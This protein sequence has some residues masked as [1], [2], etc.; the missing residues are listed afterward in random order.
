VTT[1]KDRK[2]RG[3]WGQIKSYRKERQNNIKNFKLKK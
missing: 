3:V 1:D 2:L